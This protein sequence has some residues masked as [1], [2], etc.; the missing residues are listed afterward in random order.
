M[1]QEDEKK[2][3]SILLEDLALL[4]SYAQELFSFTPLPIFFVSPNGV[5]LEANPSMEKIVGKNIYQIIG[6]SLESIFKEK[7][8]T[9]I[10]KETLKKGFVQGE[11][12]FLL[13]EKKEEVIVR[14]FSQAR[15][16][17]K[18]KNIGCFFALLDLT[19]IKK[20][21]EQLEESRQVLE[22]RVT[23]KTRELQSLADEL[24][25]NVNERTKEL[26]EKIGELERVNKLMVGREMKMVE[27]K[28][29]IIENEEVIRKIK[30]NCHE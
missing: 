19:E 28:E 18:N 23:A 10:L 29:K 5:I 16:N 24:E 20:K 30:K 7:E 25:I 17:Q 14:V 3:I 1:N 13:N 6:E 11:E 4:E 22:V 27:L 2:K 9:E 15:K 26:E 8:I 21:E 12:A